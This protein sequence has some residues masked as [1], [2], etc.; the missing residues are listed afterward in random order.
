M[1]GVTSPGGMLPRNG[2]GKKKSKKKII[3]LGL[4][5][6]VLVGLV[7]FAIAWSKRGVVAVQTAKVGR[8]D[9]SS[10][11]TASGQ[12][13][14]PPEDLANVNANS[15]GKIVE[16]LVHEGDQ[17]KKGQ[18]LLRTEDVQQTAGVDGQRA[19]IRTNEADLAA[20]QAN[21]ESTK[22]AL[23]TAQANLAQAQVKLK[24]ATDTYTRGQQLL[25][26]QL[27]APQDFE[28]RL[29]D[30]EVAKA[31]VQ[32]SQSQLE[33]ARA[34]AQQAV[35]NQEMSQARVS[36]AKAQL[37]SY[38]NLLAQTIYSS[39]M[40][41]IITSL[42]VHLGENVVPGIQN[43][44]GSVL[45]QIADMSVVTAEV[46]VD[47][48]DVI[49]IKLDQPADVTIDAVP[50]KTFKGKVTEIGQSAVSRSTGQTATSSTTSNEEAKDFKVVVTLVNPPP[51]LRP[52]L[53]TTAKIT[54]ATRQNA[55]T[56]PIQALAIRTQRELEDQ[57]KGSGGKTMAA[58]NSQMTAKEREKEKEE[59]QGLFVVQ[60]GI[61][62][63]VR[64]E[65]GIMGSTDVEVTKGI[66]PGDEIVTG[67]YQVLRTL[68]NNT[69]VTIEKTP[70]AG[71][72]PG[73]SS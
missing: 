27:L 67:S 18:L 6:I 37:M 52:G 40:N 11:V 15:M 17:V 1:S 30:Y 45:F 42:P 70:A 28:T 33:Q 58:E 61:A 44:V 53:S 34:Q 32:S 71:A 72:N 5:A 69:K 38:D 7:V 8:Q 31:T 21:V 73:A 12:I 68:K 47:E 43:Q 65:T 64:V 13:K 46:M 62:K 41:G 63:F 57:P 14:P 22:A 39:P 3:L 60:K 36:Q 9:I 16:L 35:S 24:Q 48:T 50:N 51:G 55:V 59:I 23:N 2:K 54:T 10:V 66:Q 49:N 20:Q 29:S 4:A 26:D 19:A 25:K 56:V